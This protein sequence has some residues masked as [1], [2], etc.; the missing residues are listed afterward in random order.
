MKPCC[1][2]DVVMLRAVAES[3]V[4]CWVRSARARWVTEYEVDFTRNNICFLNVRKVKV[5]RDAIRAV[6][7]MKHLP[8]VTS[9]AY[10]SPDYI[11]QQLE[12]STAFETRAN[13]PSAKAPAVPGSCLYPAYVNSSH[14][15][16][17]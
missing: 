2:R 12:V 13:W 11:R 9:R 5:N 14:I 4:V 8:L 17:T 3:V 6:N 7:N 1:R 10:Q 16:A 15:T